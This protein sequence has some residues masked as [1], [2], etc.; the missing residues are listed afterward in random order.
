LLIPSIWRPYESCYP[1]GL[2]HCRRFTADDPARF[3][4]LLHEQ[5]TP[6]QLL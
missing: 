1:E 4:R 6:A 5:I 2:E 3:R